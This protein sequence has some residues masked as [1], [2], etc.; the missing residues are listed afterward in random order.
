MIPVSYTHLVEIGGVR[1]GIKI[2]W[3]T[4]GDQGPSLTGL[5][6]IFSD[7][8]ANH[9]LPYKNFYSSCLLYTAY[10]VERKETFKESP[11]YAGNFPGG[12]SLGLYILMGESSWKYNRNFIKDHE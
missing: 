1:R 11:I 2:G 12:I 6:E 4:G 3:G 10:N 9:V 5:S 8:T 7:P